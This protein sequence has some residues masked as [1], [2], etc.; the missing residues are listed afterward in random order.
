MVG[1]LPAGVAPGQ[2]YRHNRFYRDSVGQWQTKYLVVLTGTPD[3]DVIFRLLT[4]RA[5]GRP[6]K[7]P[8]YHGYPYPSFY[9]GYLSGELTA[10]SWLGLRRQ[11]DYDGIQF[12][13]KY[14]PCVA[15]LSKE[16]LCQALDCAANA[17][18]TTR[19][20]ERLMRDQRAALRCS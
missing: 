1:Q 20:Q 16:I 4:S 8:C 5:N 15:T 19:Q 12:S 2:I 14:L 7:P 10:K 9:L 17:D 18:D 13:K 3:G 6:E 11:A